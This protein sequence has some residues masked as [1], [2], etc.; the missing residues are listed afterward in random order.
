MSKV[1]VSV[2][3]PIY[4][5]A[6]HLEKCVRSLQ[7]QTMQEK[8]II[9]VNDGSTDNSLAIC[10]MLAERD[11]SITVIDQ[12]NCGVSVARNVGIKQAKGE[13]IGFVDADDWVEPNMYGDMHNRIT[14]NEAD[15]CIC[16][17]VI[18]TPLR[19]SPVYLPI[20]NKVLTE[21]EIT[22]TLVANLLSPPTLNSGESTIMGSACRLLIKRNLIV[23]NGIFFP[24][25]I[26]YKEDLIFCIKLFLKSKKIAHSSEN[27][28]HY[29]MRKGSATDTISEDLSPLFDS[30]YRKLEAIVADYHAM[31][32]LRE[33]L[34]LRYVRDK[35]ELISKEVKVQNKSVREKI[36]KIRSLCYDQKMKEILI[37]TN[38]KGYTIR[39]K[40]VL[41]ALLNERAEFLFMYYK[42]LSLILAKRKRR[43]KNIQKNYEISK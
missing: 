20:T 31:P 10:K 1:K 37:H 2:V 13:Y 12:K 43:F 35:I 4:N 42:V 41:W 27:H 18:E 38:T 22:E 5:A 14:K 29:V 40:M 11:R 28:Y 17:Y 15:V 16:N 23:E 7:A 32:I 36:K 33:R 24:E 30:V 26:W 39:R 6:E 25:G 3:V 19:T 21:G 34:D 8:E 9:L